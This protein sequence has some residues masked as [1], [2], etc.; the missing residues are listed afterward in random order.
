MKIKYV[1]IFSFLIFISC[2]KEK[3]P[4]PLLGYDIFLIAGQSN[5]FN[6]KYIDPVLDKYDLRVLQL[7]RRDG[8]DYKLLLAIEP[9]HHHS[10]SDSLN[11]FALSFAKLYADSYLENGRKV[12]LIPCAEN[13]SGF[14]NGRWNRGNPLFEDAVKRVSF[15]VNAFPGSRVKGILWHQGEADK[16]FGTFYQSLL[17]SMIIAMRKDIKINTGQDSI[18]FIAGGLVPFWIKSNPQYAIIDSVLRA[19]PVSTQLTGFA[20]A[21]KPFV[22]RKL[23]DE[24]DPIH[25]DAAGQR[26]MARRYFEEYKKLHK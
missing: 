14:I 19:L 11:G 1:K 5:T 13:G 9:L 25:F 17:E 23:N 3:P 15:C 16:S 24:D 4:V 10:Y 7:G 2:G 26:E 22:I 21:H 6:G 8:F 20:D 18:P 12:L